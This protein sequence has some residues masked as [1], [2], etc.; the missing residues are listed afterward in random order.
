MSIKDIVKKLLPDS[1]VRKIT[2][3]RKQAQ[4]EEKRRYIE[5]EAPRF[6]KEDIVKGLRDLGIAEGDFVF[7]H[8]SLSRLGRVEGGAEA[9]L[10][11]LLAAVG[12]TGTLVMPAFCV[13]RGMLG[14][15]LSGEVFDPEITPSSTG[16]ICEAFRKRPEAF[17]S[18]HPT[19]SLVAIGPLAE[20]LLRDHE[21]A[22][23]AVGRGSPFERIHDRNG[24]ILGLAVLSGTIVLYRTYEDLRDQYPVETYLPDLYEAKYIGSDKQVHTMRMKVHDPDLNQYRLHVRPEAAERFLRLMKARGDIRVGP[25]GMSDSFLVRTRELFRILDELLDEG[26]TFYVTST[27]DDVPDSVKFAPPVKKESSG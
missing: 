18:I 25:V 10:D 21:K 5:Q 27:E 3:K 24:W 13:K 8:A 4:R 23:T 6:T 1:A 9:V 26:I 20:E 17:R 11:A 22:E 16:A 12:K 2:E 14:Q 19:H 7:M 15:V